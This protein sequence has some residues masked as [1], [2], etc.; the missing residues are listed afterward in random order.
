MNKKGF[1]LV[2]L[3][4]VI[5][6]ISIIIAL[7]FPEVSKVLRKSK[8]TI[9]DIQINKI[10]DAAYDYTLKN[11]KYLPSSSESKYITLNELKKENLIDA[12]IKDSITNEE[13]PNDL[14]ISIK[15]KKH[16]NKT[17]KYSKSSGDYIY[18]VEKEFMDSD[19]YDNN[20][21]TITFTGYDTYPVVINLNIGDTYTAIKY[22]AV[23]ASGVNLS[24]R[25]VEN[26]IYN[27]KNTK[28]INTK[29]AGIYYINYSVVD[30]DGYSNLATVSVIVSDNEKPVLT[31]PENVTISTSIT[32]YDLLDGV[33][34][35]DNSGVCDINTSGNIK[36]GVKDKYII[37]YIASDPSGNTT[38]Q[39]RVITVE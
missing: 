10:L 6:I 34:C 32:S 26:I 17:G 5:L 38:I 20:R 15:N 37:E 28:K 8:T 7:V 19:S 21:P 2:E 3:L 36:F 39:K 30:D 23:S 16:Q 31:I 9:N 13:F 27:S 11:T 22:N 33:I 29:I 35:E 25:V 24:D 1:T 18:T 12:D 14:V 4:G